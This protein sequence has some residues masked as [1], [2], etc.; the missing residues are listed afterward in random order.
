M[1]F[2]YEPLD[3]ARNE[4]RVLSFSQ[5]DDT[6]PS[7]EHA[8]LVRC[9][10]ERVSLD[11]TLDHYSQFVV[12][13]PP[14]SRRSSYDLWHEETNNRYRSRGADTPPDRASAHARYHRFAWGD[15][16]AL[17]YT[18]GDQSQ[19]RPILLNR[20][21]FLVRPN[22]E[23]AL[24][25][26]ARYPDYANGLKLWVDAICINQRDLRERSRQV[27]RMGDIFSRALIVTIWLGELSDTEG[28][29]ELQGLVS[30]CRDPSTTHDAVESALAD[31]DLSSA[32]HAAVDRL[33]TVTYWTR[34]WII[35]EKCLAPSNASLLFGP[36]V[37]SLI[38]LRNFL[39]CANNIAGA[40]AK[41]EKAW[42]ILQLMDLAVRHQ[43]RQPLQDQRS[44][45]EQRAADTDDLA[46]LL[47]LGRLA[48][49]TDPRDKLYGLM[50]LLPRPVARHIDPDY[51]LPVARVF[52]DFAAA[53]VR[54]LGSL[55][56]VLTGHSPPG[57]SSFA[58]PFNAVVPS[59]VPDLA[60]RWDPYL[61][62]SGGC[63]AT[64]GRHEGEEMMMECDIVDAGRVLVVKA[65]L[66]DV[67][68]ATAPR[69]GWA[70]GV[71]SVLAEGCCDGAAVAPPQPQPDADLK[72]A[73]VRTLHRD[74]S[75]DCY[76]SATLLDVPWLDGLRPLEEEE[77]G[78]GEAAAADD[79]D[80]DGGGGGKEGGGGE[81]G[82]EGGGGEE[83]QK[84]RRRRRQVQSL[85]ARGWGPIL[86]HANFADFQQFRA[87]L[88]E[89]GFAPWPGRRFRDFFPRAVDDDEVPDGLM[90]RGAVELED[91][92]RDDGRR[93][94]FVA[95][96][97]RHAGLVYPV[98]TTRRGLFGTSVHPTQVGD[99]VAVVLGCYAPVLLRRDAS[100]DAWRAV[101]HCYVEGLMRGEAMGWLEKGEGALEVLRI[102]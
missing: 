15:Y 4:I 28:M 101:S 58:S 64:R 54:G 25:R 76:G 70:E 13:T 50:G 24:R 60:D 40:I 29:S 49:T 34:T 8:D 82:G 81:G 2:D 45:A 94:E 74:A 84:R 61:W 55:D 48:H 20:V 89:A 17:S 72:S 39:A 9:T 90:E 66:C 36:H 32:L 21:L 6:P 5:P 11:E 80:D 3:E 85:L 86:R 57:P 10:L 1:E 99:V 87:R 83:E 93:A 12:S 95:A 37:F 65:F 51:A 98:L 75:L 73:I 43:E 14:L 67:V 71:L 31:P 52:A 91:L 96:L 7:P 38:P 41:R 63:D 102:V 27:R 68:A 92:S 56:L 88:D 59:W 97:D 53:L 33:V 30:R 44:A 47:M 46:L 22:L 62:S 42:H 35:Q 23:A 78:E 77:E 69:L 26:L 18:W 16:G 79:D 19:S 100:G